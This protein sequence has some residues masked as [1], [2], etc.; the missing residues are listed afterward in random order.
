MSCVTGSLVFWIRQIVIFRE[1][2]MRIPVFSELSMDIWKFG[3]VTPPTQS[4]L[5]K[6]I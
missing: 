1:L 2:F 3:R 5:R 6:Y 4:D